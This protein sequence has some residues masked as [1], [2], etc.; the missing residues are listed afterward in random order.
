MEHSTPAVPPECQ[1]QYEIAPHFLL[2]GHRSLV[3]A[4]GS[5]SSIIICVF[6]Y[7]ALLPAAPATARCPRYLPSFQLK[8]DIL[9]S[10]LHAAE[11]PL[12]PGR[13]LTCRAI[14]N[15]IYE[16]SLAKRNSEAAKAWAA[17]RRASQE[18]ALLHQGSSPS[19]RRSVGREGHPPPKHAASTSHEANAAYMDHF[20][21]NMADMY[22][23]LE[24]PS[25]RCDG[26]PSHAEDRA[27]LAAAS[28]PT[29]SHT[30]RARQ[31]GSGGKSV[32]DRH[33]LPSL[34]SERRRRLT[35]NEPGANLL[36]GLLGK[37]AGGGGAVG[38]WYTGPLD[39]AGKVS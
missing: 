31:R 16:M 24:A 2:I 20:R 36:T 27:H 29:P 32:M 18:R 11:H 25:G 1:Q 34:G 38:G 5:F 6:D 30:A 4:V 17:K 15:S 12:T 37:G 26:I 21:A 23:A 22:M 8:R 39:P 3:I 19:S 10:T 14:Y 28:V 35:E 9:R 33:R 13:A 7:R